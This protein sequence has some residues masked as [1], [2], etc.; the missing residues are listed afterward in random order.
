VSNMYPVRELDTTERSCFN[1]T[2]ERETPREGAENAS[3]RES[4]GARSCFWGISRVFFGGV[5]SRPSSVM[6]MA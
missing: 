4:S 5:Q 6:Q 2:E 1:R 3:I